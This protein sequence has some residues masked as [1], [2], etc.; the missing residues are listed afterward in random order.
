M[1]ECT[2]ANKRRQRILSAVPRG[3]ISVAQL[4]AKLSMTHESAQERLRLYAHAGHLFM[5]RVARNG[6]KRAEA[7]YFRDRAER[8]AV[9]AEYNRARVSKT[10]ARWD[11]PI[12]RYA[13]L[14][15]SNPNNV[16]PEKVPSTFRYRH[17]A[18]PDKLTERP[19]SSLK[20]GQYLD[21]R[22]KP[23]VEAVAA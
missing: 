1:S 9:Q 22:P 20:P 15:A 3:G 10:G 8:D 2:R 17:T 5:A 23:W 19:F 16:Q 4:A 11:D 14:A 13:Q 12:K 21:K 7:W 18:E 6:A